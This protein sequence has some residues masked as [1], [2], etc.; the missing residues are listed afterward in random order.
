MWA[1]LSRS[2][3]SRSST[4]SV[5]LMKLSGPIL[6]LIRQISKVE[7]LEN[8]THDLV[9]SNQTCLQLGLHAEENSW[10]CCTIF[11]KKVIQIRAEHLKFL[12]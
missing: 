7:V 11:Y 3:T 6:N 4:Y 5:V 1:I 2:L 9:V 8:R 12:L 10:L